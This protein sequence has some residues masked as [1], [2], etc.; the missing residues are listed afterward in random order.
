MRYLLTGIGWLLIIQASSAQDSTLTYHV[1]VE[2][3]LSTSQTPFWLHANRFGTIPVRGPYVAGQVGFAKLA[4]APGARQKTFAWS[5]G[6]ELA[7]FASADQNAVF[8]TDAYVAGW[9]GPVEFS[10]GQRKD[11][12]GLADSTLSSGSLSISGNS[13]PYPRARIAIPRYLSLGFTGD[14]LAFKG[15]YSD[16]LLGPA[17]IQPGRYFLDEVPAAYLHHK[18]LYVRFGKPDRRFHLHAGFNHQAMWGGDDILFTGGLP[19]PTQYKYVVI[20]KSWQS[21]RV[22]NHLGTIDL[23]AEWQGKHWNF[24]AYRQNLY[25]DGSLA[26]LSNIVDGLN[27]LRMSR[28]SV[29]NPS[30]ARI[31]TFLFEFVNTQSQGGNIFDWDNGIFGRDNYYNHYVYVQGWSYRGRNLGS[32]LIPSQDLQRP[33]LPKNP[34]TFTMDNRLWAVHLAAV[35]QFKSIDFQ[36][37]LT[38]SRHFGTYSA[39]LDPARSQFSLLVQAEKPVAFAG[40]SLLSLK[41]AADL[42]DLYPTT[43]ALVLGWRKRGIF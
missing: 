28:K 5:A 33:E 30:S 18:E 10:V 35:G 14:F 27:G 40:G 37:R 2:T 26:K 34:T 6:V 9:V 21:S 1:N 15:S 8:L 31:N 16:G 11:I 25:E 3:A 22:G 42:G 7:A 20:G 13:R 17:A 29:S 23:A 43:G 32:P 24:F 4:A 38:F 19:T 41:L 39:E 36:T 12:I